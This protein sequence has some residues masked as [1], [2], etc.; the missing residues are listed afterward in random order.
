MHLR[1]LEREGMARLAAVQRRG[2]VLEL[3]REEVPVVEHLLQASGDAA[4]IVRG[5]E[6][7]RDDDELA[8]ARAVLVGGKL[9][10]RVP[11]VGGCV[12]GIVRRSR[13]RI[14]LSSSPRLASVPSAGPGRHSRRRALSGFGAL[15]AIL[16]LALLG[17]AGG[18][19]IGGERRAPTCGAGDGADD[20]G[21]NADASPG[22]A[23]PPAARAG[24]RPAMARRS[25][26]AGTV[27]QGDRGSEKASARSQAAAADDRRAGRRPRP[28]R[29][30]RSSRRAVVALRHRSG[31]DRRRRRE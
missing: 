22:D 23:G 14:A 4:G 25:R 18:G 11:N 30:R 3:R 15:A 2:Q 10:R 9:H 31:G 17:A 16:H 26:A 28:R 5:R 24:S 7:A 13:T 12:E 21:R 29:R 8:V 20:R 27:S 1:G 19:G 6:V